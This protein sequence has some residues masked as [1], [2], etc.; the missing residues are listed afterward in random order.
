MLSVQRHAPVG[1]AT[2]AP[3]AGLRQSPFTV[4]PLVRA[5]RGQLAEAQSLHK[6]RPCMGVRHVQR[7]RRMAAD[8]SFLLLA[9]EARS[10]HGG[11]GSRD[12]RD[13]HLQPT[14]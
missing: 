14:M 4:P 9:R 7:L 8:V 10:H 2:L 6:P 12:P 13:A 1:R 3:R 5:Q 11:A